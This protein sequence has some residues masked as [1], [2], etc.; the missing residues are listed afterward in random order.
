MII[1]GSGNFVFLPRPSLS[2]F[3]RSRSPSEASGYATHL[4]VAK[5]LASRGRLS[6]KKKNKTE[7]GAAGR[8]SNWLR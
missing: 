1:G 6:K 7:A 4:W 8:R 5:P 3:Y 2:F